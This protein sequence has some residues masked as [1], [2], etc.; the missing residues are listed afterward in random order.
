MFNTN[1]ILRIWASLFL[2][3]VLDTNAQ[4]YGAFE[5]GL[6][7]GVSNYLGEIGG[8][9]KTRRGF[10]LDLKLAKTRW[11]EGIFIKYSIRKNFTIKLAFDYVRIQ[12][13]DKLTK[14]IG[15]RFRN[16]NFKNDIFDL[17]PTLHWIFY[18]KETVGFFKRSAIDFA[19]YI[20]LGVGA[21]YHNPKAYYNGSWVSLRPLTTENRKYK[22]VVLSIPVG[23]G[24]YYTV[25]EH[26]RFGFEFNWHITFTDYLDDISKNYSSDPMSLSPTG[27]NL[28]LRTP[29][30]G[31]AAKSENIGAYMSHTWGAKRGDPKHKD[32]YLTMS[33][34][35]SYALRGKKSGKKRKMHKIRAKF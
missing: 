35:Y 27:Q 10:V 19:S 24:F 32:T 17:E 5:Y 30:L 18:K 2:M 3:L 21:F 26:N 7:S 22:K 31:D 11:A 23:A 25:N 34:S 33:L 28:A 12:G 14:N 15:R 4:R 1:L 16:A 6:S 29:E 8:K 20:F 9:A 13:D